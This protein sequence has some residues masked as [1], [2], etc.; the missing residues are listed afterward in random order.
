MKSGKSGNHLHFQSATKDH[1]F[2]TFITFLYFCRIIGV[3]VVLTF[4]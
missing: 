4:V 2:I 3:G 1:G